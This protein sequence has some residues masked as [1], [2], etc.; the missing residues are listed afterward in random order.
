M[1]ASI[2]RRRL[3]RDAIF[4][5]LAKQ[6]GNI[7]VNRIYCRKLSSTHNNYRH[8]I[9]IVNQQQYSFRRHL[10]SSQ[11]NDDI[12]WKDFKTAKVYSISKAENNRTIFDA[13]LRFVHIDS[14][15]ND[16]DFVD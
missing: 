10:S 15:I 2:I 1:S 4:S 8:L 14:F 6:K 12:I 9:N 16:A 5:D 7:I 11:Q 3:F 13:D